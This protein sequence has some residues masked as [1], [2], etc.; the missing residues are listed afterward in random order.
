MFFEPGFSW[1][2]EGNETVYW[3]LFKGNKFLVIENNGQF[4]LPDINLDKLNIRPI[5]RQYVGQLDGRPCYVAELSPITV[6]PE[7]TSFCN[8]R[9]LLDH[10]PEDLFV[11]AG[12]A[13]QIMH[14]DRSHQYC[15]QCGEQTE[16]KI[17]ERAKRCPSCGFVNYPRIS[18][19]IIV[20]ITRRNEILLA[21]GSRFQA[22]FYSVLAGFVEPGE[23]FEECVQREVA[24][25]VGI[26]VKNIKYFGSQP[27]PF[28]DSLMVGF[29][30]D[31]DSGDINIDKKEILDA[32]WFTADQLPLIPSSGSIARQL[33]DWFSQVSDSK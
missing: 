21:K 29:I 14:W 30:A 19:A 2:E 12:K 10:M 6:A 27:W 1:Q 5:R 15:S 13:Y 7:G 28:P 26:K 31:Y 3:L 23:T 25:E 9:R 33:I 16:N 8:L 20:A 22:G 18:P 32:R 11:L 24:E 17:D 4:A